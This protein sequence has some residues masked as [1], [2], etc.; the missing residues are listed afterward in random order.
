MLWGDQLMI[1]F[2]RA[3]SE[4]P[5]A[6][7][8][9]EVKCSYTLYDDIAKRGG[10]A[11]HVEGGPLA[12][13]GEDEGGAALLAGEMSGHIFFK[14][15]YFGFDDAVYLGPAA[16]DP[17]PRPTRRSR[18]ARRRA[19][20]VRHAGD[21]LG[22]PRGEEVRDR[23]PRTEGCAAAL[24]RGHVDGVRVMFADGWGLV[25][26]SNTQPLLVLRFEA[27]T[28]RGSTRSAARARVP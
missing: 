8:V 6:A 20:H 12:D 15:R 4:E 17:H 22:H 14:H 24:Q 9:G 25:R 1:L 11:D 13:Q 23:P 27:K 26:A 16:G 3:C 18:A 21:A 5:G 19:A 10:R 2:A 28:R 7:I